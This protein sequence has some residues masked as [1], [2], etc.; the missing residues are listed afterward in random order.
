[1]TPLPDVLPNIVRSPPNSGSGAPGELSEGNALDFLGEAAVDSILAYG[2]TSTSAE[3]RAV[4]FPCSCFG[5]C[6]FGVR[7]MLLQ[8]RQTME[9]PCSQPEK[10]TKCTIFQSIL[11]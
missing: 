2:I 8:A 1:M 5:S 11:A 10:S 9:C 3:G 7:D 4:A 6:V